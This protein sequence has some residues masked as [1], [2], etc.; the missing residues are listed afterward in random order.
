MENKAKATPNIIVGNHYPA[1]D[2]LRG[3][4]CLL[5]VWFHASF[6]AN[7]INPDV[8]KLYY[9][10][11]LLGQAGV[12]L[13]FVLSGF[14]ITGILMDTAREKNVLKKFYIRRSLRIFPLY[15]GF[16]SIFAICVVLFVG[17]HELK[18]LIPYLFYLQ[19]LSEL[20][21]LDTYQYLNH[22]WSLAVEE[23][24][25]LIWPV[26][27]LALYKKSVKAA[28]ILC[29]TAFVLSLILRYAMIEAGYPKLAYTFV[30]SHLDGLTIGAFLSIIWRHYAC[31]LSQ[32]KDILKIVIAILFFLSIL[33]FLTAEDVGILI[34]GVQATIMSLLFG[35]VL[36]LIITGK[37]D[38]PINKM[39]SSRMLRHMGKISYGLYVFHSP[40]MI[41]IG[42]KLYHYQWGYWANHIILLAIGGGLAYGISIISYRFY[43]APILKL[44]YKYAP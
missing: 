26:M 10:L 32:Y 29:V 31:I 33:N 36:V 14:L 4:A 18:D 11:S 35:C 25:Y 6:F 37:N 24:F 13:F 41:F 38:A 44:K 22:T 16:L 9:N 28:I 1:I 19:N 3:F 5:V 27:F 20:H 34:V 42:Y 8:P 39:F 17:V 2:G 30:L 43:E 23:Q 15:Y 40:I 12:D 21:R 7:A